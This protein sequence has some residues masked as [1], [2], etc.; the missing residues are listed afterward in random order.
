MSIRTKLDDGT[1]VRLGDRVLLVYKPAA[2]IQWAIDNPAL[3]PAAGVDRADTTAKRKVQIRDFAMKRIR[4][5]GNIEPIAGQYVQ[6]DHELLVTGRVV[7]SPGG[8]IWLLVIA[9]IA[10]IF[11]FKGTLSWV[12]DQI[13]RLDSAFLLNEDTSERQELDLTEELRK[14]AGEPL[15]REGFLAA[16]LGPLSGL[17]KSIGFAAVALIAFLVIRE[18]T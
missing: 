6:A 11:L 16:T 8:T 2:L 1:D 15:A 9:G 10:S 7:R 12:N 17:A 18:L 5:A 13:L 14:A 3:F 4:E